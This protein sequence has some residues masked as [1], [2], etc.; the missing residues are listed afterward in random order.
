MFSIH[1]RFFCCVS[2]SISFA[3]A[4]ELQIDT[5][6]YLRSLGRVRNIFFVLFKLSGHM[7]TIAI[8]TVDFPT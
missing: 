4:L 5:V 8:A 6:A 7:V 1:L 3:C 2:V